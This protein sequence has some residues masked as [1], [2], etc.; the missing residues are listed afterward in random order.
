MEGQEQG[1]DSIKYVISK[2]RY[3]TLTV[4]IMPFVYTG[5]YILTMILYMFVSENARFVLDT[6]FYVSPVV[7]A[8]L[9]VESKILKLCKWHKTACILPIIPQITV[10][11]DYHI[12]DLTQFEV[13]MSIIVP[14]AMSTLLLIA[15]YHVFMK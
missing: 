15:A 6:L 5:L 13:Y 8:G 10:F 11:V 4:Q 7:I 9:L 3:I 2:L 1:R 14:V 12:I